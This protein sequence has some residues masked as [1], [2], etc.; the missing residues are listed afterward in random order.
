MGSFLFMLFVGFL[1]YQR[2]KKEMEY[3]K[4]PKKNYNLSK[5]KDKKEF[6]KGNKNIKDSVK[7][8]EKSD[9]KLKNRNPLSLER[10]PLTKDLKT[11]SDSG[12]GEVEEVSDLLEDE[13]S[14]NLGNNENFT[15]GEKILKNPKDAFIYSEIFNRKY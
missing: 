13:D 8:E 12:M 6:N 9:N 14:E 1:I 5:K 15:I 7:V 11:F 4:K 2:L 3:K 10:T